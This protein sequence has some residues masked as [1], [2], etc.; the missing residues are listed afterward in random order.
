MLYNPLSILEKEDKTDMSNSSTDLLITVMETISLFRRKTLAAEI[1]FHMGSQKFCSGTK[2]DSGPVTVSRFVMVTE[3]PNQMLQDSG[4]GG[5]TILVQSV[6]LR[7]SR[8]HCLSKETRNDVI[9]K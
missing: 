2:R 7:F 3:C 5:E 6:A 1:R 8:L 4:G 9:Y